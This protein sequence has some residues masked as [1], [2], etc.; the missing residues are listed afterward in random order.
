[1]TEFP[2]LLPWHFGGEQRLTYV[3]AQALIATVNRRGK[4][5]KE[6]AQKAER[7]RRRTGRR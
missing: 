7:H 3:E 4:E 6:E 1:M 2:G 5:R